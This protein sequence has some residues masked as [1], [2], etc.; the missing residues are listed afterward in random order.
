MEPKKN[1]VIIYILILIIV[2]LSGLCIYLIVNGKNSNNQNTNIT[3][4]LAK[5]LIYKVDVS[6]SDF[7]NSKIVY[8]ND[9]PMQY[10]IGH[11]INGG[12]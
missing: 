3:E 4:T 1:N 9:I 7:Y 6:I 11:I 8:I 5:E 2:L 10:K 12:N